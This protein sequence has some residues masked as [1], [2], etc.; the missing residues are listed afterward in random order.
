MRSA[1]LALLLPAV[2]VASAATSGCRFGEAGFQ[3]SVPGRGF[4]PGGT[5]FSYLDERD[6][7]L[8]ED[9]DP[10]VVVVMTWIV[11]DPT[12]DLRDTEGEELEA[13]GHELKQR[14][15]LA[16]VFDRQG[17]V[18]AGEVYESVTAGGVEGG[19]GSFTARVHLAPERLGSQSTYADLQPIASQ[20]TTTVTL[21]TASF[22]DAQPVVAGD[23]EIVFAAVDGVDPGS[24]V[25][26]A[27]TGS[28]RA[29]LVPERV[30]ESNLSVLELQD[31]LGLPLSPRGAP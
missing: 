7:A 28:F 3:S 5:V 19:D 25:E 26:G 22:A 6:D 1:S 16:L 21:T 14:D 10:R 17:A 18:D 24:A 31:I 30:A 20:R 15:A 12:R 4:E 2:L 13:M 23:V 27:F 29:P 11:F 8:V 9:P